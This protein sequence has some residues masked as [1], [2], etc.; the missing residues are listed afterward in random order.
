MFLINQA[1][2]NNFRGL[3]TGFGLCQFA[4]RRE[5]RGDGTFRI[6]SAT[7]VESSV[8]AAGNEFGFIRAHRVHVRREE[9]GLLDFI[10]WPQPGNEIAASGENVLKFNLQPG[11]RGGGSEKIGVA[12]QGLV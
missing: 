4:D 9:N 1:G 10:F 8:F 12:E 2:K 7:S 6:A 5:H 3:R 11:V